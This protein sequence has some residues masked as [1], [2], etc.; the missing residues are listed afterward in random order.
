MTFSNP[1][2]YLLFLPFAL[3]GFQVL[4]RFGRRW[5]IGFLA[6]ISFAFYAAWST[7]YLVLLVVSILFNY[8]MSLLIAGSAKRE[9]LQT[10]WLVFGISCNLGALVYFKYLFPF[11]GFIRNHGWMHHDWGNV[12]L[13]LGISFFTFTQIAY[14]VDLKQGMAMRET[15]LNYSLFVTF[16]PHLIAGPIIHNKEMMPQFRQERRYRL[17]RDDVALGLTWFTMGMF[18]KVVIADQ[19]SP[20]AESLFNQ[21]QAAGFAQ[22]WLGV[23]MY[24]MQLYFDFSGYSDMAVGLARMFSIRFPFN[25]NSPYKSS[26]II[27]FWQRWHMTLTAYIMDYLY[28]P[29]QFRVSRW[30]LDHGKKISRKVMATPEGFV[31]MVAL[32]TL[33]TLFLAGAWHGAGEKFMAYGILHGSYLVINHAWRIFVPQERKIRRLFVTPVNV[34]ITFVSVLVA[35]TVFRADTL[36]AA[37]TIFKGMLGMHG[38]GTAWPMLTGVEMLAM[39]AVVWLMPNTQEILGEAQKD[40]QKNWSLFANVRWRPSMPWWVATTAAGLVSVAYSTATSTFLYFQF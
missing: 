29:I 22:S 32:P 19:I 4:G 33:L 36:R 1:S 23:L 25:F 31:Q 9:A 38:R 30:R 14:L 26:S 13:P 24:A 28:S 35:E 5:A 17:D 15:L 12:I 40:D 34:G 27:D 7:H 10:G 3:L 6:L 21:P 16:F 11:L 39:F 37:G 18:K 2:F 8:M 20:I